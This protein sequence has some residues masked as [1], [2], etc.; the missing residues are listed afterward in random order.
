[1]SAESTLIFAG[2]AVILTPF[3]GLPSE[4]YGYIFSTLGVIV[5][6]IG[7]MF[8]ARKTPPRTSESEQGE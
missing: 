7:I 8:R 5:T 2:I 1:M 4:W 6:I 3:L